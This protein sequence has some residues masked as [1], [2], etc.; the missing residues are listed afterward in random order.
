MQKFKMYK[1]PK[2]LIA[3]FFENLPILKETIGTEINKEADSL[4]ENAV[5]PNERISK[6]LLSLDPATDSKSVSEMSTKCRDYIEYYKVHPADTAK[7]LLHFL[8][9]L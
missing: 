9:I 5:T 8:S 7:L 2:E 3:V 4:V 6:V 1:Y